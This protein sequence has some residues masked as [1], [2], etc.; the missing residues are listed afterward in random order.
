LPL[1]DRFKA[2]IEELHDTQFISIGARDI[3]ICLVHRETRPAFAETLWRV[4][5]EYLSEDFIKWV[6]STDSSLI[7][8]WITGFKPGG[9]DSRPDR[10]LVPMARML[11]GN[12]IDLLTIVSGPGKLDMWNLLKNSPKVLVDKSGLWESIINL[13]DGL[14]A[15]SINAFPIGRLLERNHRSFH[16]VISFQSTSTAPEFSEMDVDTTLHLLFTRQEAFGVFECMCNPPGGDWSGLSVLDERL[17]QE[18]RWTS[19]PRVSGGGSK[20]PDQFCS[21]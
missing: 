19:L 1:S 9:E 17:A 14:L 20:R 6:G 13:S 5:Q 16:E 11:F 2:L 3:P 18:F 7:I 8:V 4:Y 21:R 10:G 12:D 15:D